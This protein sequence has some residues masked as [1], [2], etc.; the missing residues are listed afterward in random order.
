[1]DSAKYHSQCFHTHYDWPFC[2][3]DGRSLVK[4]SSSNGNYHHIAYNNR[5]YARDYGCTY[6]NC[7]NH[8]GS[9]SGSY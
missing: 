5:Q 8:V 7:A 6:H 2:V 3:H 1:M 4:Y 9:D